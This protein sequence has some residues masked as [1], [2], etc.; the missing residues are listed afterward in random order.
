M[1]FDQSEESMVWSMVIPSQGAWGA[2][3][4]LHEGENRTKIN[5]K[6]IG[7]LIVV[8]NLWESVNFTKIANNLQKYA[9][10]PVAAL[11]S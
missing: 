2:S 5:N 9:A 10:L 1:F 7:Y 3:V 8:S 11:L 4:F 6:R